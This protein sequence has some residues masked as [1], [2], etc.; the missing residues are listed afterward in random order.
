MLLLEDMAVDT[1][2]H[3]SCGTGVMRRFQGLLTAPS[4][5]TCTSRA[6]G[7]AWATDRHPSTTSVWR[8]GATTVQ[9]VARCSVFRGGPLSPQRWQRGGAVIRRAVQWVPAGAGMRGIC[10][11]TTQQTAGTPREG[12]ARDRQGAS[13]ARP[14]ERTWRG[15]HGVLGVRRRPR[16]RWPGHR[17]RLPVGLARY[18]Q[19]APAPQRHVPSR[20][21]RPVARALRAGLAP[22]GPG[23]PSRRLAAGGS[24]TQDSGRPWPTAPHVVGRWPSRAPLSPWPPTPP[25]T[26]RGAPR[27]T[28]ARRGAPQPLAPTAPGW[29]PHP[30]AAGAARH[31]WPGRWHAGWPGRRV[32]VVGRRRAGTPPPP[33]PGQRHPPPALAACFTTARTGS[34]HDLCP[35]SDDRWAVAMAIRA[36]QACD[37]RGRAQCRTRH[38]L[39]GAQTCRLVMAAARTRWCI[40]QVERGTTCHLCY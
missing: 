31:A 23:R 33:Q 25:P 4:G 29:A 28:G 26:R 17:R 6:C 30:S 12:L 5:P 20:S 37:G 35:E 32:R 3:S 18:R 34:A 39:G 14:A 22:P 1:C 11:E 19:P 36:T 24:A 15:V 7:W 10:D 21:R 16:T 2:V 38:R 27:H 40:E 9:H 13:A 8:T